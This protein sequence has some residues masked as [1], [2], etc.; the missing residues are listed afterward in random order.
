MASVLATLITSKSSQLSEIPKPLVVN[1]DSDVSIGRGPKCSLQLPDVKSISQ[2]HCYIRNRGGAVSL[3]SVS[4]NKTLLNGKPVPKDAWVP[5]RD[6]MA[7]TLSQD[8]KIK[9]DVRVGPGAAKH[10]K[11][12]SSSLHRSSAIAEVVSSTRP[13]FEYFV[14]PSSSHSNDVSV[15][16]GRAKDCDITIDNKKVSSTHCKLLFSRVEGESIHWRL[17]VEPVSKNKSYL[18]DEHLEGSKI[19][20]SFSDPISLALVFPSSDSPV[21]V[22]TITP[23]VEP[24]SEERAL[25]ATEMIE[26]ELAKEEKRQKKEL[27]QL[28]K[29][30]KGWE[31][32][33]KQ[34]IE[35]NQDFE[36]QLL[37]EIE[38]IQQK[39]KAKTSDN[40][41]LNH[42]VQLEESAM[43]R[44]DAAFKIEMD[45]LRLEHEQRLTESTAL[46]NA[47]TSR[48]Q[49]L[50]EEKLKIQMGLHVQ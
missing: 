39:I 12:K 50:T 43:A 40:V 24:P 36:H 45:Q 17:T 30:S 32:Q 29:E 41:S 44:K 8:P 2:V 14:V 7:I 46:V 4:S 47:V 42:E 18:G 20:E 35:K 16:I 31:V 33:Y 1:P 34:E 21:E 10:K 26:Q 49:R 48:F 25:T 27:R 38:L 19:F 5:L 15:T 11:R 3:K 9:L 13:D 28:E 6:G 23:I 37:G 22:L